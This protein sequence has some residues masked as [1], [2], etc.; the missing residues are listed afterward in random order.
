MQ[1]GIDTP[2]AL[3]KKYQERLSAS[4]RALIDNFMETVGF[5]ITSWQPTFSQSEMECDTIH[6]IELLLTKWFCIIEENILDILEEIPN[7]DTQAGELH[8]WFVAFDKIMTNHP[9]ESAKDKCKFMRQLMAAVDY[10]LSF[11]VACAHSVA[12]C[13]FFDF[14][15]NYPKLILELKNVHEKDPDNASYLYPKAIETLIRTWANSHATLLLMRFAP[16]VTTQYGQYSR[17]QPILQVEDT[18]PGTLPKL[19]RHNSFS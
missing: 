10:N 14:T 8:T 18:A 11:I 12:N 17:Q 19:R 6:N 1:K 15:A 4:Q 9:T 2:N 16:C 13:P 5:E 3:L 7:R